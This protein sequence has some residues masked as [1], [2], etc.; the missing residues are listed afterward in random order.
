VRGTF[1]VKYTITCADS[2]MV[3]SAAYTKNVGG[4][5]RRQGAY[6]VTPR[7]KLI[8]TAGIK[9]RTTNGAIVVELTWVQS[10]FRGNV[11]HFVD[12]PDER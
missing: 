2:V 3:I 8:P 9:C 1:V 11:A 10:P 7:L 12:P 6:D 4:L 5:T